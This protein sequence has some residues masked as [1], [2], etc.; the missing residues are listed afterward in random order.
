MLTDRQLVHS[1]LVL[2][3]AGVATFFWTRSISKNLNR[4]RIGPIHH[5]SNVRR[6]I[7]CF[8]S[9]V[10]EGLFRV[11]QWNRLAAVGIDKNKRTIV[12]I[13]CRSLPSLYENEKVGL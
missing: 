12:G 10:L 7:Q 8:I 6:C 4:R 11:V 1:L 3:F 13:I 9:C 2:S 5:V